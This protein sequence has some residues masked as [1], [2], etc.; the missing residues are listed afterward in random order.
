MKKSYENPEIKVIDL[1]EIF[2]QIM[3]Q[4]NGGTPFD[5]IDW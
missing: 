2:T 1:P 5:D 3:G 4:S